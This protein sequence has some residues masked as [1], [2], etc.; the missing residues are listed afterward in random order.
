MAKKLKLKRKMPLV[1][2][3]VLL[4]GLF[5]AAY[6]L[7]GEFLFPQ[8]G[9]PAG[10]VDVPKEEA[11]NIEERLN[12]LLLGMDA[13][14]CEQAARTDTMLFV[15]IDPETNR[16]AMI[17][18]PRDTR[19]QIPGY[20]R[21]RINAVNVYGGPELAKQTVSKLLGVPVDYYV[22][23]NFAGF[24]DI[25]DAVG[26]VNFNVPRDMYY[27]G[28]VDN[29]L[30][31]LKKGQQLLDGDKALQL[32]R[33]RGYCD[34]DIGRTGQQQQ[35]LK[36]LA[37]EVLQPVTVTKLHKLLPSIDNAVSTNLGVLQMA[38]LAKAAKNWSDAEI[39]TQTLPGRFAEIDGVSYWY[40]DP[41]EANKAVMA[42]FRGET[43]DVVQGA[44][45]IENTVTEEAVED[46]AV[47]ATV[48]E[49]VE[50]EVEPGIESAVE[51]S[52]TTL[53]ETQL[54]ETQLD[55]TQPV[56][57]Q[58]TQNQPDS[59]QSNYPEPDISTV[60]NIVNDSE[61]GWL[62]FASY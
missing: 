47:D 5:F 25:V 60:D 26:G 56:S 18:I 45:I 19:V 36:A 34:G 4:I 38:R 35:F 40:V 62:P 33:F 24:K 44:T 17:S 22:L 14:P 52:G 59:E 9:Q 20:G 31:D 23:T 58:Q 30:I 50:S 12:F 15:S 53:D 29:T 32:I 48:E 16:I 55:E 13:R 28:P 49:T 1:V 27:Y 43:M 8:Q 51:P 7:A 61:S 10:A 39:I 54:D 21:N 2:F 6:I 42:L 46:T 3:G 37:K 41:A 11:V 57:E